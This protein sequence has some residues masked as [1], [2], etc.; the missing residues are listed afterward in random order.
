MGE[1]N[2]VSVGVYLTLQVLQTYVLNY[3]SLTLGGPACEKRKRIPHIIFG[4]PIYIYVIL[5]APG[6]EK[7]I[8]KNGEERVKIGLLLLSF[9]KGLIFDICSSL[10]P[11]GRGG[12]IMYKQENVLHLRV[13]SPLA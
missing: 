10:S 9:R 3:T 4:L 1:F 8:K 13:M 11:E 7:V 5:G 6:L 2:K 12:Q